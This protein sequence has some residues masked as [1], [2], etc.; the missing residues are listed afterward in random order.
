LARK[1]AE[2]EASLR[3]RSPQRTVSE[4]QPKADLL[5]REPLAG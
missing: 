4:S 2:A 3:N 5:A 1:A